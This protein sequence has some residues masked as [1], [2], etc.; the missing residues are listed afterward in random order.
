MTCLADL[1]A[2][3]RD[4]PDGAGNLLDSSCIYVTSCTSL[5]WEHGMNDFPLLVLG[6]AGGLLKGDIHHR[7]GQ[8]ERE[9]GAVHAA[10]GMEAPKRPSVW[11]PGW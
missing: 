9:Q 2:R 1:A 6:K 8:R 4:T 3:F 5:A 7:G 10:R 11:T